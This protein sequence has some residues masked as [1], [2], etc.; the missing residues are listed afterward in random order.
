MSKKGNFFILLVSILLSI[1]LFFSIKEGI[2]HSDDY[3]DF[4]VLGIDSAEG[5]NARADS[6]NLIRVDFS[7]NKI[8][9]LSIPRDLYVDIPGRGKDKINHSHFFGGPELT[10]KTVSNLLGINIKYYVELN[11]PMFM[12][13][14]DEIGGVD[15]QVDKPMHYDDYAGNLH[16]HLQPGVRKLSGYEA[17]GFVRF[18]KDYMSDWGRIERQQVFFRSL[19]NE[20]AKPSNFAKYPIIISN[21]STY[22]STNLGPT[23]IVRLSLRGASIFKYGEVKVG[24]IPGSDIRINGIYYTIFD[25]KDLRKVLK[26]TILDI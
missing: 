2:I 20:L 4:L 6:I 5:V 12:K 13:L 22:I 9:I 7:K 26:E 3:V 24:H 23:D 17:M 19:F 10:C 8:G 1:F 11:F 18:R 14:I 25:K 21:I 16:I 15:V